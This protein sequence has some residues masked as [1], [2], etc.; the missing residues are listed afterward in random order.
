MASPVYTF[1]FDGFEKYTQDAWDYNAA[2]FVQY[3]GIAKKGAAT[4]AAE[5]LVEKFTYDGDNKALT[6]TTSPENSIWDNRASLT[7]S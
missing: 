5:W 4:S 3:H 1:R 2:G 7:Y 6:R